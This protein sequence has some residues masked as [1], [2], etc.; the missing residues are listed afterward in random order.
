[1]LAAETGHASNIH[2]PSKQINRSIALYVSPY[3]PPYQQMAAIYKALRGRYK[4]GDKVI[5]FVC[6]AL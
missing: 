1:M 3:M 2:C 4:E 5:G 6:R